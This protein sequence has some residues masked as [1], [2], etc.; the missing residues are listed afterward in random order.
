LREHVTEAEECRFAYTRNT[1]INKKI[2]R[3]RENLEQLLKMKSKTIELGST[4]IENSA[5][6]LQSRNFIEYIKMCV[7]YCSIIY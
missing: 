5:T 4:R 6:V 1:R 3:C 2:E 7:V